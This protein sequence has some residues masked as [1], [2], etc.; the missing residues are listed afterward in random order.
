MVE[1]IVSTLA[2]PARWKILAHDL[3]D[4]PGS[5]SQCGAGMERHR[6]VET[7]VLAGAGCSIAAGRGIADIRMR[8]VEAS[9][10]EFVEDVSLEQNAG[11]AIWQ[12]A[13]LGCLDVEN[14]P[15]VFGRDI[16]LSHGA[17]QAGV[18]QRQRFSYKVHRCLT[19]RF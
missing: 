13:A 18:I 3:G 4:S 19:G 14:G 5:T 15:H 12:E 2:K 9:S 8:R 16:K 10:G 17:V 7:C 11:T 1:T 6:L